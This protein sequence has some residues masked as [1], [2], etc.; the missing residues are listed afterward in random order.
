MPRDAE[1]ALARWLA[2]TIVLA[3]PLFWAGSIWFARTYEPTFVQLAKEDG[4]LENGQEALFI[5]AVFLSASICSTL[6]RQQRKQWAL[7]YGLL[8]LGLFW[9]AGEEISWGQRLFGF[10]TTAWF[11]AHNVQRE[12]TL[13]NLPGVIDLLGFVNKIGIISVCLLSPLLWRLDESRQRR[14]AIRLWMPHPVLIPSWLCALSYRSLREWY[15]WRHPDQ[16]HVSYVVSKLQ[17]PKELIFAAAIVIFLWFVHRG[18]T[19]GQSK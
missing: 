7:L 5:V 8:A 11:E 2:W 6:L 18:V 16:T 3:P 10:Q 19:Q 13:H 14:W 15:L 4:W 12:M 1:K 17:E 9:V